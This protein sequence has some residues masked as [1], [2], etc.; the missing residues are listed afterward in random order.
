MIVSSGKSAAT[1][2]TAIGLEYFSRIPPP[3]GMPGA[4]AGLAGVE[5]APVAEL[6]RSPRT[7]GRRVGRWGRSP[8]VLGWNLNPRTPCSSTRRRRLADAGR[9]LVRVDAGERDQHVGVRGGGLGDLLVGHRR[10]RR[11]RASAST[12]NTTAAIV[13]LAVVARPS[14]AMVG[15]PAAVAE[16]LRRRRRATRGQRPVAVLGDHLDVGVHV[17]ASSARGRRGRSSLIH[18]L[19]RRRRRCPYGLRAAAPSRPASCRRSRRARPAAVGEGDGLLAGVRPQGQPVAADADG[20]AGDPA[21][22][23]REARKTTSA[24]T[25]S[26]CR[27]LRPCAA[28]RAAARRCASALHERRE[29]G[30]RPGHLGRG[31]GDDGVDGDAGAGQLHR[32]GARHGDDAGLGGGVVGLAEVAALAGGRA[33]QDQPAALALL[34]E[35]DGGGAGAGERAAQVDADDVVEV[36]VGHLPQHACRAGCPRW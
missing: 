17:D 23:R 3:P 5:Q 34:A 32:P 21:R 30:D 1:S 16:V 14:R 27:A 11:S 25:S 13:A 20:L 36:L 18:E 10:V 33:D 15:W 7:A 29:D 35:A 19:R 4:D 12:V 26:G 24:A 9:A 22:R 31:D 8:G 28:S 2:S 6:L